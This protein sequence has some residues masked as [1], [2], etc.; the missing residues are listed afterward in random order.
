[1]ARRHVEQKI[2]VSHLKAR[3]RD[4]DRPAIGVPSKGKQRKEKANNMPKTVLGEEIASVGLRKANVHL[5]VRAHS[6]MNQTRKATERND[7]VHLLRQV[8]R[9]ETRKVRER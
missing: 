4:E 3:N 2:K 7:L 6:S 9:T 1:M 5:E 8:H